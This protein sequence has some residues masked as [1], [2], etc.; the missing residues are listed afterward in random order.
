MHLVLWDVHVH[1]PLI[2]LGFYCFLLI[3]VAILDLYLHYS[4]SAV[5]MY[6][7]C[8]RYICSWAYASNVKYMYTRVPGHTVDCSELL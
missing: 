8:G 6:V 1:R 4:S 7:Q 3:C 5:D 2:L